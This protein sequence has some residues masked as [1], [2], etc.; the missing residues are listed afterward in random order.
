[1]GSALVCHDQR[2]VVF[3]SSG[4]SV[5][6]RDSRDSDAQSKDALLRQT[7]SNA[8]SEFRECWV[9]PA[10]QSAV[11]EKNVQLVTG[12]LLGDCGVPGPTGTS[13]D[14]IMGSLTELQKA[15]RQKDERIRHLEDLLRQRDEHVTELQSKLDKFQSVLP[16]S[17]SL[18]NLMGRT[19]RI[20]RALG[21]SAEPQALRSAKE[22]AAQEFKKY[23][24][25]KG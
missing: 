17:P 2:S 22:M 6:S 15:L 10:K 19:P 1:M 25:S 7:S 20:K 4:Q 11:T 21:I 8:S 23:P 24:K 9:E 16:T 14:N 18:V 13:H 3:P 5:R 12:I